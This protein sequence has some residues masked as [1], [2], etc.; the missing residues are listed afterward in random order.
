MLSKNALQ[1]IYQ[2][3]CTIL[4][5]LILIG[6]PLTSLPLLT[7]WTNALVA[8]FS[9]LPLFG[10]ILVWLVPYLVRQG[11]FP[12]TILP[13]FYFA[14][15]AVICSAGAFFLDGF[16]LRG[17]TFFDQ[18]LRAL[19]TL[20]I[21][22]SFYF[23]LIPYLQDRSRIQ[24][25]LL[26]IYTGGA[27]LILWS[28]VEVFLIQTYGIPLNF[29]SWVSD[30]KSALVFQMPGILLSNRLT[31]FAYEPSWYV[32]IFNLVFFPLWLSAVYQRK[33]I[34]KIRL[35]RFQV[36]DL[37]LGA[38]LFVFM[39]S[40][41]RIGL[42]SLI[43]MLAFI[44]LMLVRRLYYKLHQWLTGHKKFKINDT[45]LTRVALALILLV[46]ALGIILGAL[47]LVIRLASQ[48]DSRYQLIIDQVSSTSLQDLPTSETD[49]ILLARGLAFL[50]RTVYWFGGW[51]VFADYPFGVGL[52]NAGFYIIDRLNSIGY[53]S[54]EI[55]NILY[56]A[57][58]LMNT[59]SFWVRLLA[60]TGFIGFGIYL[61]WLYLLWRNSTLI[62]SSRT[63]MMQIVGLAGKLFLLAHLVEG[64]SIDSFA[65]PY[66]WVSAALISAGS[67]VV[68]KEIRN[69]YQLGADTQ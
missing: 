17:L 18:S 47:G 66:V 22:L 46:I 29:P 31:G 14:I 68:R 56:Q 43:V 67:L 40:F 34:F 23:T 36:E 28:L 15:V 54:F 37:L 2:V 53:G 39:L 59:K 57:D 33:S 11:S 58:S 12:K 62:Q 25:A 20:A 48:R 38:S 6:L 7:R 45:V 24:Q 49:I 5:G 10:L 1:S 4:F 55:R 32:L 52:G 3:L 51:N 41:P 13:M 44:T 16:Y 26:L 60:E 65:F 21:G 63:P 35:W 69:E 50:E 61:T 30:L 42:L 64:F 19:F 27:W 9:A 8:P